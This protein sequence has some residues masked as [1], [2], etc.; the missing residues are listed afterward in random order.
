ML[1]VL[2]FDKPA[3]NRFAKLCQKFCWHNRQ[4]YPSSW[5]QFRM[6]PLALVTIQLTKSSAQSK[7]FD[8]EQ[9]RPPFAYKTVYHIYRT[10]ENDWIKLTVQGRIFWGRLNKVL[11]LNLQNF[12]AHLSKVKVYT[13]WEKFLDL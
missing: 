6:V 8:L 5:S 1:A 9:P 11:K 12:L 2:N 7:T 3:T 4:A 13:Q 10:L